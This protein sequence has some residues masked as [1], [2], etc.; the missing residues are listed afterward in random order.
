MNNI[1]GIWHAVETKKHFVSKYKKSRTI[2]C[3]LSHLFSVKRKIIG[4]INNGE[5]EVDKYTIITAVAE[6][7]KFEGPPG[8]TPRRRWCWFLVQFWTFFGP[9]QT[10]ASNFF[11]TF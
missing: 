2:L 6:E 4:V 3:I 11:I 7:I 9:P 8:V 10:I 1:L 5:Q